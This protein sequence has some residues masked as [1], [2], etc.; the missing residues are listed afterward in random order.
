MNNTSQHGD[1]PYHLKRTDHDPTA[2]PPSI[3]DVVDT[4]IMYYS[5]LHICGETSV[6]RSGRQY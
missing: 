4:C 2:R 5:N 1:D 3:V 6:L